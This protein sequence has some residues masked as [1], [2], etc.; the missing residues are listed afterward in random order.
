MN[1]SL[2]ALMTAMFNCLMIPILGGGKLPPQPESHLNRDLKSL[3]VG[4]PAS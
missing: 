3:K 4:L 2:R 1:A